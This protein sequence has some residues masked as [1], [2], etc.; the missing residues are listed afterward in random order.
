[1]ELNLNAVTVLPEVDPNFRCDLKKG[2]EAMPASQLIGLQVIGFDSRGTS[3]LEMPIT[4]AITFDGRVVQGG[5][6]GM[7][8]DYAGVSAATCT[9]EPGWLTST[10]SFEVHNLAPA[11]GERLIA[12]GTAV[13]V[14]ASIAVSR[15]EVYAEKAGVFTLVCVATTTCKPFK[16]IGE[17]R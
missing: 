7:L 11:R 17:R 13:K 14:G 3:R 15:A 10:T 1:M 16:V 4:A 5:I 8:A 6:V 9:L 2:I 12:I